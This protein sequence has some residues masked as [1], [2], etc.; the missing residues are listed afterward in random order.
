[1]DKFRKHYILDELSSFLNNKFANNLY[2]D[3][4][5]NK[6]Y[7]EMIKLDIYKKIENNI[8]TNLTL[9]EDI[10]DFEYDLFKNNDINI[11]CP[12][13]FEIIDNN[14]YKDFIRRK[15]IKHQ[16][17]IIQTDIIINNGEIIIEFRNKE[18]DF[19]KNKSILIG[20]INNN[21]YI[22][23]KFIC[24]VLLNTSDE[25]SKKMVAAL[26][27]MNYINAINDK[28]LTENIFIHYFNSSLCE[29]DFNETKSENNII[30]TESSDD[31][32]I[33]ICSNTVMDSGKNIMK[34]L[35]VLFLSYEELNEKINEQ[36]KTN[37]DERYFLIKKDFMRKYKEYYNYHQIIY[38]IQNDENI[39]TY[40]L[41]NKKQIM[42]L[43]KNKKNYEL[44]ISPIIL[45]IQDDFILELG[46]KREN[47]NDI[48][49]NLIADKDVKYLEI[50]TGSK[51]LL[52]YYEG[53]EILSYEFIDLFKIIESESMFNLVNKQEINCFFGENK[54]FINLYN[55]EIN[56]YYLQ[57]GNLNNNIFTS[58]L[59]I[60]FRNKSHFEKL[61]NNMKENI[62]IILSDQGRRIG[63]IMK[64]KKDTSEDYEFNIP[65]M[66]NENLKHELNPN[67]Q[68][69]L[70]LI[71][72]NKLFMNRI[73]YGI[74]ECETNSGYL[75]KK[76]FMIEIQK[77]KLYQLIYEYIEKNNKIK[78]L[79]IEETDEDNDKL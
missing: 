27:I 6:I 23:S 13:N 52:K 36:I 7:E 48:L 42:S 3:L 21:N 10:F 60:Y 46:K 22:D 43:I 16:N 72:N 28:N 17:K 41:Q 68:K 66:I 75:I 32:E 11:M 50:E 37:S 24:D 49:Q 40:L 67:S 61:I 29:I 51:N 5:I 9:G 26:K 44:F 54:V 30:I 14:F 47:Q 70:K 74:K 58:D 33:F 1:M 45:Q 76:D 56:Y 63:K 20:H 12:K 79:L 25:I 57:I 4:V 39:K 64:I 62:S 78:K 38:T 59:I 53:N 77:L 19:I 55:S 65:Q 69:I 2:D 8:K 73:K 15:N 71:I 18:V 35:I 34:L 31:N